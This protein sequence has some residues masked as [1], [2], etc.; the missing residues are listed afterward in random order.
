MTASTSLVRGE[1][2]VG[3]PA[4][5]YLDTPPGFA[6]YPDKWHLDKRAQ[7]TDIVHVSSKE[8]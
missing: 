8:A 3:Y 4:G 1:L 5:Q 7:G 2:V 6:V